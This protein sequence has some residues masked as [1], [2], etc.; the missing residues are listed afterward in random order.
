MNTSFKQLNV[1][2]N[3]DPNDPN[4]TIELDGE[5][6]I[7]TFKL[8][9]FQYPQFTEGQT[10]RLRFNRYTAYRM[11]APNDEGWY[12]GQCRFGKLAPHWGDFYEV[13]GDL[14]LN[15]LNLPMNQKADGP[16]ATRHFLFYLKDQTFECQAADWSF[17]ATGSPTY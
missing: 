4:P 11:G 3:A 2:W 8:N 6:L 17:H 12:R 5:D 1:A 16:P 15:L 10:A 13:S 14:R 7:L 9:A